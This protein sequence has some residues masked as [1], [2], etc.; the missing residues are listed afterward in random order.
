MMSSLYLIPTPLSEGTGAASTAPAVLEVV[1]QLSVFVVE[2]AKSARAVLKRYGYPRPLS[3]AQLLTLNEH[4][5]AQDLQTAFAPL[6]AG[7]DVG[8]MSEAGCP[9]VADPGA[10]LVRLA[11]QHGIRVA[12]LVGASSI[13]L[14]LMGSGL[15]GQRFRF[16]GYLPAQRAAR[17]DAIRAV[18]ER[19]QRESET[20]IFIETPYRSQTLFEALLNTC[21][22]A[23]LLCVASDLTGPRQRVVTQPIHAWR[24]ARFE[25]ARE[26]AVYLLLGV[27]DT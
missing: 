9:A 3:E 22:P 7:Q 17:V 11:H 16:C 4:S 5:T 2:N 6:S 20:Q 26:P 23:T 19:S 12:P 8:L 18:E 10:D 21:K 14:A 27:A 24:A 25:L 13:L 1:H 15:N